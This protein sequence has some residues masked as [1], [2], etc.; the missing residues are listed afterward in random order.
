MNFRNVFSSM[1]PRYIFSCRPP[2]PT[3]SSPFPFVATL[4]FYGR[5]EFVH[6]NKSFYWRNVEVEEI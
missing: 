5:Y 6:V 2:R 4:G 3:H 1:C